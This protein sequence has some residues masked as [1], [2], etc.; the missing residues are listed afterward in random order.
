MGDDKSDLQSRRGFL[1]V[2]MTAPLA[3]ALA[4]CDTGTQDPAKPVPA[5]AKKAETVKDNIFT[6]ISFTD[7]HGKKFKP[8]ELDQALVVFGYGGCPMC[9]KITDS[10]EA[11]QKK[12]LEDGKSVPIVVISVQPEQDRDDL[13]TYVSSY[14]VK[15]VK[16]FASET[17]PEDDAARRALGKKSFETAKTLPQRDRILHVICPPDSAAAKTLQTRMELSQNPNKP[18]SHTAYITLVK[19]GVVGQK[20]RSLPNDNGDPTPEFMQA[21][22][23]RISQSIP[24]T[25]RNR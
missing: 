17:L 15:G 22:A 23:E 19:N 1:R 21:L 18:E 2:A 9:Q 12:L 20:F 7:Q 25:T 11:I 5:P 24:S 4:A 14:Y 10:V 16:Q 6:G 13:K 3:V 8:E